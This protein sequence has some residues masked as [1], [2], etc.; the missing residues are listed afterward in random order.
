MVTLLA[1][2]LAYHENS[3]FT[4]LCQGISASAG[5]FCFATRG[6][7]SLKNDFFGGNHGQATVDIVVDGVAEL[8]PGSALDD[9]LVEMSGVGGDL[10]LIGID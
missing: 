7:A 5:F 9:A 8:G 1:T 3:S 2:S 4:M 6:T 10:D